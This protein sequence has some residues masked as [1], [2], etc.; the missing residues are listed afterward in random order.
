M[1]IGH[2]A[3]LHAHSHIVIVIPH[4]IITGNMAPLYG[5][6]AVTIAYVLSA[7]KVD[8]KFDRNLSTNPNPIISSSVPNLILAVIVIYDHFSGVINGVLSQDVTPFS[9]S[10]VRM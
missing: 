6:G 8:R 2:M 10:Q 1:A 7:S 4:L 5:A 3:P 9:S